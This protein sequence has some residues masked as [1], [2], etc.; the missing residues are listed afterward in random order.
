MCRE[1]NARGILRIGHEPLTE[2]R[3]AAGKCNMGDCVYDE[4]DELWSNLDTILAMM[5]KH[6]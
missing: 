1:N 4:P 3:Q 2:Q 5:E 6:F